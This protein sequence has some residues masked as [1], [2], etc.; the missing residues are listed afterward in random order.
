MAERGRKIRTMK[1]MTLVVAN[2]ETV[3]K[4]GIVC[5]D[6]TDAPLAHPP[7]DATTL[8]PIGYAN[9]SVT[10]DGTLTV[11]VE[12]FDEVLCHGF[13]N[14]ATTPVDAG[15]VGGNCWMSGPAE[16][17]ADNTSRSVAGR[18]IGLVDG[19]VYVAM[20]DLTS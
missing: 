5:L 13:D 7:S 16:V 18:V 2:G 9:S 10:G 6:T 14:D 15:D 12:L 19:V 8:V 3:E 4:G 17:S 1:F 20:A 11:K